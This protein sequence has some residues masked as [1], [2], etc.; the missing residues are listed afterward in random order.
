MQ[1]KKTELH[2]VI[3]IKGTAWNEDVRL[4]NSMKD[5]PA[6]FQD[7]KDGKDDNVVHPAFAKTTIADINILL[8]SSSRKVAD[9]IT[10]KIKAWTKHQEL[11]V[12]RTDF[13]GKSLKKQKAEKIQRWKKHELDSDTLEESS[14]DEAKPKKKKANLSKPTAKR[15]KVVIIS[16]E[17]EEVK[18]VPSEDEDEE[19]SE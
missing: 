8:N 17:E 9:Y 2:A 18:G 13:K 5:W 10:T 14:D 12:K 4:I 11:G 3:G 16:E 15:K 7:G 19:E 6:F 1:F